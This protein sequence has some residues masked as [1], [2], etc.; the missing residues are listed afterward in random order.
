MRLAGKVHKQPAE[1]FP[2]TASGEK[3]PKRKR[4]SPFRTPNR[5]E[6]RNT[7]KT[8][9]SLSKKNYSSACRRDKPILFLI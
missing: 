2:L 3:K 6:N 8:D 4:R 7:G 1:P 9:R 5:A